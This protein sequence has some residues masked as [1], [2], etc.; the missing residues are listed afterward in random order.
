MSQDG[1]EPVEQGPLL[2]QWHPDSEML[3]C[4]CPLVATSSLQL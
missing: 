3:R 4:C 1:A 2:R